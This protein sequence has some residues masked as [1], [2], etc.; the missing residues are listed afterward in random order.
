MPRKYLIE[1]FCDRVAASKIYN[2]DKYTDSKPLEYFLQAK[3]NRISVINDE[4]SVEIGYLL[5]MLADKRRKKRLFKIYKKD[6]EK[7]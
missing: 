7:R 4:T 1:M 2:K 6:K 5:R 3:D